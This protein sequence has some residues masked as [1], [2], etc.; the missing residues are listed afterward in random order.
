M[1]ERYINPY[2]DYGFKKLFGT[3]ENKELLISFLN[4][5]IFDKEGVITSL[6][7]KNIEQLGDSKDRRNCYFDVYCETQDGSSFIVEMQ[8]ARKSYFKDRSLFFAAKPIRDQAEKGEE[9]DFRLNNVYMVGVMN[10]K[11]PDKEYSEDSYY[12]V[13]QLMDVVDQHVFYDKLTLIY[14]EMPKLKNMAPRTDSFRD[15]WLYALQNLCYTD[16][17]PEVLRDG[18]FKKLYEA[19]AIANM[20]DAQLLSYERSQKA[21]WDRYS[22][23][24]TAREEGREEGREQGLE[25]GREEARKETLLEMARKMKADGIDVETICRIT[26]VSEDE[27]L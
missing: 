19:A 10:F 6:T 3:E 2:T 18:I 17:Y 27:I 22:E 14:L 25:Q 21:M 8:N 20:N 7:Y 4:A 24:E 5:M 11:F 23:R 16:D 26:G 12:H 15:L 1:S 9:W 13:I